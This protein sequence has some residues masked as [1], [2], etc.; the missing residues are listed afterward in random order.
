MKKKIILIALLSFI[1][2]N[3][4]GC[5]ENNNL[6]G[7]NIKTSTY[8]VEYLITRLYGENTTITS[9]YPNGT[10][11]STYDLT[12]KQIKTF[13]K[14]TDLFVY[15][16]LT[17]EKEI[18]KKIL[19]ENKKM[20]IIDVSYGIKYHYGVEELWLNPNNYL[21]LANTVKSDLI[22][23]SANKYAAED[24]EKNYETLEEDLSILDTELRNIAENS[25]KTKSN[26]IV[27]AN[28]SF[29]F[30]SEYGF[31]VINIS[32]EN[33]ITSSIKNKFKNKE[34]NHIL[35]KDGEEVKDAIRDLVDNYDATLVKVDTME[36]LSDNQRKNNDNYLS[37]MNDFITNIGNI[38]L[39]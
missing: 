21:M 12:E 27:V 2:F 6:E 9:I 8:P 34:Y 28:D 25:E 32:N 5:F 36:T 16:G 3:I 35:V 24:I 20:Q 29:G 10:S 31:E 18:A 26:V 14:D 15:N 13:A 4:T 22:E 17:K 11:V 33:N 7:A 1:L 23:L 19:N 39:K 30:L 37:I 38:T